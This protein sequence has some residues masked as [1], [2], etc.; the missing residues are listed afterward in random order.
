MFIKKSDIDPLGWQGILIS[1]TIM[2][3]DE[4]VNLTD[5]DKINIMI[6][7]HSYSFNLL[8]ISS[9]ALLGLLFK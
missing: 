5:D 2:Y 8:I 7:Y 4:E 9:V 3:K 6:R 1:E